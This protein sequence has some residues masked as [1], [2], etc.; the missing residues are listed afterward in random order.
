VPSIVKHS[1]IKGGNRQAKAAA[2]INY[3][4]YRSGED[5]EKEPRKFFDDKRDNILGREVKGELNKESGRFIH[6]IIL[7]P[8]I[9]NVDIKQY[10]RAI[11]SQLGRQKGMDL[12]W[13]AIE[14]KNTAHPHGH[15]ILYSKDKQGKEVQIRRE[16]H[17]LMR[18]LGDRY[19]ERN[20]EHERFLDKDLHR[21]MKNKEYEREG[22]ATYKLLLADLKRPYDPNEPPRKQYKA[23]EWDR[24]K[25]IERLPVQEKLEAGAATYTKFSK[26]DDLKEYVSDLDSHNAERIPKDDYKM[27]RSWIGTKERGGDDYFDRQAKEKWDKREKKKEK[28]LERLPGEDER[29]FKKLAKDIKKALQEPGSERSGADFGKGRQQRLRETQGRLGAEHGHFTV[30]QEI[31]K[32]KEQIE[33]EPDRKAELD[34]QIAALKKW[35]LE[36]RTDNGKW[37]D[38]DSLL[39]ERYAREQKE[40]SQLVKPRDVPLPMREPGQEQTPEQ[41]KAPEQDK[42]KEPELG[43][44]PE[45]LTEPTREQQLKLQEL[46]PEKGGWKEL[47]AMFG[48][49]FGRQDYDD[50]QVSKQIEHQ[51]GAQQVRQFQDLTISEAQKPVLEQEGPSRDDSEDLFAQGYVR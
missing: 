51:Q 38:L 30:G 1:Y 27:L 47:D 6:K 8:G 15:V 3:L 41:E 5:R 13:R 34:E 29:E 46:S 50:R 48:E 33:A 7:S 24:E 12:N 11:F 45:P 23:K 43:K 35:D 26:L 40:L 32:L 44:T 16:D 14:H 9:E 28:K 39:G 20:H 19:I 4:Q 25:A 22:D 49:R 2:H 31:Q 21:L 37:K 36:Q 18:E 42:T 10:A 17:A